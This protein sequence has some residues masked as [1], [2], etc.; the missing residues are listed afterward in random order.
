MPH[1]S[2]FVGHQA[3]QQPAML[4]PGPC[5]PRPQLQPVHMQTYSST[6]GLADQMAAQCHIAAVAPGRGHMLGPASGSMGAAAG[7]GLQVAVSTAAHPPPGLTVLQQG[8]QPGL[9]PPHSSMLQQPLS[10]TPQGSVVICGALSPTHALPAMA[11]LMPAAA[12]AGGVQGLLPPA[13][14]SDR[15]APQAAC[16]YVQMQSPGQYLPPG[17]QALQSPSG[18]YMQYHNGMPS[19]CVVPQV[20]QPSLLLLLNRTKLDMSAALNRSTDEP[21]GAS[22]SSHV[23]CKYTPARRLSQ[24]RHAEGAEAE[25]EA[26]GAHTAETHC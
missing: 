16:P 17:Q 8:S 22:R 5:P 14:F 10:S 21:E 20:S 1:S 23:H 3:M 11:Q 25:A 26:E 12:A 7:P 4:Q 19:S 18:F 15:L 24:C 13:G 2:A 6:D 9:L